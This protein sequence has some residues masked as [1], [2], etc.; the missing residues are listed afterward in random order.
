M[1]QQVRELFDELARVPAAEREKIFAER[2]IEPELRAEVESL[3]RFDE[4]EHSVLTDC[5]SNTAE[6]ILLSE[7]TS[8]GGPCGPYRLVRLL[9]SGGMGDVYLAER[10]DG[11]VEQQVAIKFLRPR[12]D[13]PAWR[14]RFLKERQLLADLSHPAISRMIDAGGAGDRRPYLVM[15]YVDGQPVDLYSKGKDL[16]AQ[17]GLF[18]AVCDAVSYAHRRLIIHPDLKPSNI[19]VDASGRPKLLDFGIAKLLDE[20]GDPTQTVER[21]MTPGYASPE[22]LRGASQTTA[23]DIYSL[24][25]VL[26]RMLTGRSPHESDESSASAMEVI[27][28]ARE[29]PA[30]RSLNRDLPGDVD[31]ILRKALRREPEERYVSVDA[32]TDDIRAFLELRPVQARSGDAWYRA[33][34]FMR[35]HWLPVAAA[36]VT[37]TGLSVGLYVANRERAIAQ[38]RFGQVRTL[39]N[40]FVFDVEDR[41]K[42]LP[43]ATAARKVIV[44]VALTYLESLRRDARGDASLLVEIAGAYEKVG[45][46][47][48]SDESNLGDR[49]GALA[50]YDHAARIL[51]ELVSHGNAS[52]RLPLAN[53]YFKRGTLRR[54]EANVK[55]TLEE[56]ARA[57]SICDRLLQESPNDGKV[58]YRA[59]AI[60]S[61]SAS[62]LYALHDIKP[63]TEAAHSAMN[64]MSRLMA[65]YPGDP[66]YRLALAGAHSGLARAQ[67]LAGQ[68]EEAAANY[69]TALQVEQQ[70]ASEDP[71][72][73]SY[74]RGLL[75]TYTNLGDILGSPTRFNLGDTDGALDLFGKALKIAKWLKQL[76]PADRL[77]DF[78]IAD[79]LTRLGAVLVTDRHRVR[80]GLQ[81]LEDARRIFA[82]LITNDPKNFRYRYFAAFVDRMRGEGLIALGRDREAA[83][84]LDQAISGAKQLVQGPNGPGARKVILLASAHLAAVEANSRNPRAL[85]IAQTAVH[86]AANPPF[87]FESP[88]IEADFADSLAHVYSRLGRL[89]EAAV[90][91]ER[92]RRCLAEMKAPALLEGKRARELSR[93]ETELA[94]IKTR[95]PS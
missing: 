73:I 49:A 91:L 89:G 22:Q 15:E 94:R 14:E 60:Y 21:L 70:L 78:D 37:I 11:E 5:V 32:L 9:G 54:S 31:A 8:E 3:L 93:I 53:V 18:L 6:E 64:L 68:L 17:L 52:A 20:E 41:I 47:Q 81:E 48:D 25:A 45:D 82:H 83:Q 19:L 72:N 13:R 58:L 7:E 23:T 79:G 76:D 77:A 28:G 10:A 66:Q 67:T 62:L 30:A 55:A 36:A 88:W 34:K 39:A 46:I 1:D 38:S 84:C 29:I 59:G 74:R 85:Q 57:Q 27:T 24:G 80:E 33:R 42:R 90:W 26:Y 2:K 69:R 75:R 61:R 16:G 63:A 44:D 4:T 50:S 86:D 92:S 87:D 71:Q 40:I 12:A 56:Y 51:S 43:G 35:R 95:Q 65:L